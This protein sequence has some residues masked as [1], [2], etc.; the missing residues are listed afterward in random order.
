MNRLSATCFVAIM[1]CSM[2]ACLQDFNQFHPEGAAGQGGS[3]GGASSTTSGS[4]GASSTT[5]GSGGASSTT[6]GSGGATSTTSGSGGGTGGSEDPDTCPGP[7]ISL[8]TAGLVLTGDTTGASN[9]AGELPC[10]GSAS[11]DFVYRVV[12]AQDGTL[13]ATL[14]GSFLAVLYARDECPGGG[15]DLACGMTH[16]PA[17]ITLNVQANQSIFLFVDGFGGQAAEGSFTLTLE[18]D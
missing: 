13:T 16:D 18:L 3:D 4:G 9:D 2:A 6:S 8:T 7:S 1:A 15:S 12:P 14:A 5:S 17:V 10:G 11:G